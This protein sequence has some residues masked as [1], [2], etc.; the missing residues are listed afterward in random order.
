MLHRLP[1]P[2][3]AQFRAWEYGRSLA[4]T[5]GF[6]TCW[7]REVLCAVGRVHYYWPITRPEQSY[8]MCVCVCVCVSEY[9]RGSRLKRCN[10]KMGVEARYKKYYILHGK[11]LFCQYKLIKFD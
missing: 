7:G 4:G 9:D 6:E 10:P 3:V 2:L 5:A 8:R 11:F 1:I